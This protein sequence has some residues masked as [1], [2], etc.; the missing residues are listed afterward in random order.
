[1]NHFFADLGIPKMPTLRIAGDERTPLRRARIGARDDVAHDARL[2]A[3]SGFDEKIILG[4]AVSA[5]LA[6]RHAEAL[7]ADPRSFRQDIQQIALAK[8]KAAKAGNC[9]LLAQKGADFRRVAIVHV[10]RPR[11]S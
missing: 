2:P 7:G 5:H 6:E 8:G 9:R 1:V 10:R 3:V 11:V 4:G